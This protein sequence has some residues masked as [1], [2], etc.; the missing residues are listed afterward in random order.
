ME[1]VRK[2][3][4]AGTIMSFADFKSIY[5]TLKSVYET[6]EKK[7]THKAQGKKRKAESD[8]GDDIVVQD[9]KR[10]RKAIEQL[11]SEWAILDLY[12]RRHSNPGQDCA[13]W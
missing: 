1:R 3:S 10:T 6:E 4:L 7:R 8:A 5:E 2:S 13:Q 11:N 9:V 12:T